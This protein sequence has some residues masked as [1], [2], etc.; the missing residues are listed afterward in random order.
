MSYR[1]NCDSLFTYN[2]MKP[3]KTCYVNKKNPYFHE[4]YFQFCKWSQCAYII[5]MQVPLMNYKKSREVFSPLHYGHLG[6]TPF[7]AKIL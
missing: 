4:E 7:E 5:D 1:H 6:L 2:L 3:V